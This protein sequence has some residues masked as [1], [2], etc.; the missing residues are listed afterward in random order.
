MGRLQIAMA[1]QRPLRVFP[2]ANDSKELCFIN[3][4]LQI[5]RYIVEISNRI[6]SYNGKSAA[7]RAQLNRT[8]IAYS[9]VMNELRKIF[10]REIKINSAEALRYIDK[11]LPNRMLHGHQDS[12]EFMDILLDDYLAADKS[13][14]EFKEKAFYYCQACEKVSDQYWGY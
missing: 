10:K 2:L 13:L 12:Q 6:Y 5:L 8:D 9:S 11:F 1:P 4:V 3:V 7:D 14:F